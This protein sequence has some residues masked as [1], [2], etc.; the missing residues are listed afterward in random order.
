MENNE[1]HELL[2]SA[3]AKE[4]AA[5]AVYS[6]AQNAT[7]DPGAKEL[8]RK[9]A[10]DERRHGRWV[11]GLKDT[12]SP[13]Q[14]NLDRAADLK[15]SNHLTGPD[16][17]DGANLQDTLIFAIKREQQSVDFYSR[18]MAMMRTEEAKLLCQRLVNQELKHKLRL[19]LLYDGLFLG[20]N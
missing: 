14:W 19:E 16:R 18:M 1:V 4:I 9:L 5:E 2:D 15:I 6:A 11:R 10:S 3:I 8:L 17:L 20:E 7:S 13:G 12:D